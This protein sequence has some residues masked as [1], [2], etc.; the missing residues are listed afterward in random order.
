MNMVLETHYSVT[1]MTCNH[2]VSTA[3]QAISGVPGVTDVEVDLVSGTA[4]VRGAADSQAVVQALTGAGYP[5]EVLD[6]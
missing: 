4:V 1:G 6:G 3:R 2:C 5:A